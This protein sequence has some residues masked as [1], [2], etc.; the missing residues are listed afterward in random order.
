MSG[1][2]PRAAEPVGERV[3]NSSERRRKAHEAARVRLLQA[4]A[5]LFAD[6][7]LEGANSNQIARAAG[8]GV[9]TFYVHFED[10]HALHRAIVRET[11]GALQDRLAKA[12]AASDSLEAQVRAIVGA[13]CDFAEAQPDFF[14]IAFGRPLP[15]A[16]PGEPALSFSTRGVEQ[17]LAGLRE[18]G[19]LDMEVDPAVAASAALSMQTG[20]VLQWLDGRLAAEREILVETLTRLHPALSATTD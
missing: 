19:R 7:G 13:L 4:G 9:G 14:R 2:D 12:A 20:V 15:A 5:T 17:R 16:V 6:R 11:F 10:K 3:R 8:A 18:A 1:V